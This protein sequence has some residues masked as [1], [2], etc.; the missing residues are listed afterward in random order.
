MWKFYDKLE[1]LDD[2]ISFHAVALTI[3][4]LKNKFK[5]SIPR[6]MRILLNYREF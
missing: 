4:S 3:L 6:K 1:K 5:N 2:S